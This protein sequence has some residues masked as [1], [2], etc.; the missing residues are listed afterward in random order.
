MFMWIQAYFIAH[1]KRQK[2]TFYDMKMNIEAVLSVL[3]ELMLLTVGPHHY[4][5]NFNL[6]ERNLSTKCSS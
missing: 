6:A 4:Q 3:T 5:H 1:R 2:L